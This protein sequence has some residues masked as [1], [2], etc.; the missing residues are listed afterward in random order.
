MK[1]LVRKKIKHKTTQYN[2]DSFY[3]P[4]NMPS[5]GQS[6]FNNFFCKTMCIQKINIDA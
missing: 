2:Q 5:V 4:E 1:I 6:I 3:C